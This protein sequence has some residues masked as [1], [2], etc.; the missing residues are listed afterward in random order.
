[1]RKIKAFSANMSFRGSNNSTRSTYSNE[2]DERPR[3]T[4][5]APAPS[6][7]VSVF[8]TSSMIA[9]TI[10]E[11]KKS[12]NIRF[13]QLVKSV[14]SYVKGAKSPEDMTY[15][16]K[17][18]TMQLTM[19]LGEYV[20]MLSS[21]SSLQLQNYLKI[22]SVLPNA[23]E[24]CKT[25]SKVMIKSN[26]IRKSNGSLP[27]R[28]Q[29]DLSRAMNNFIGDIIDLTTGSVNVNDPFINESLSE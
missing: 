14:K 12:V 26:K 24:S 5:S 9:M 8:M 15:L 22:N 28:N 4:A 2:V 20:D 23:M 29:H 10:K 6:G 13:L 19:M 27:P 7:T 3:N 18:I 1:M 17:F 11:M 25:L 21:N 16:R